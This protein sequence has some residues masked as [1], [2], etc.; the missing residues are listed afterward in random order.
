LLLLLLLLLLALLL[1]VLL[2]LALLLLV[3][4]LLV[5][6]VLARQPSYRRC[7]RQRLEIVGGARVGHLPG[8]CHHAHVAAHFGLRPSQ[9]CAHAR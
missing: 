1:L 4:V 3:V 5:V 6:V 9:A 2:L 7:H 8:R